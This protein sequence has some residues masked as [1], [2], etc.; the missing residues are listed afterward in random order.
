MTEVLHLNVMTACYT[1]EPEELLDGYRDYSLNPLLSERAV[2]RL[3][4]RDAV[5]K[6]YVITDH[7]GTFKPYFYVPSRSDNKE[8]IEDFFGRYVKRTETKLPRNVPHERENYKFTDESDVLFEW[9][10]LIDKKIKCGFKLHLNPPAPPLL[11]P[12]EPLDIMPRK[13]Y[14]D[15]E[16]AAKGDLDIREPAHPCVLITDYDS[17]THELTAFLHRP[18]M[19]LRSELKQIIARVIKVW[20]VEMN[21]WE[22][23]VLKLPEDQLSTVVIYD[24]PNEF[25]TINMWVKHVSEIDPDH[26]IGHNAD[27]FDFPI[28]YYRCR[29]K[30]WRGLMRRLSPVGTAHMRGEY[31]YIKGREHID[32]CG[33]KEKH[34]GMYTNF[35]VQ[36]TDIDSLTLGNLAEH[37]L[38]YTY[39]FGKLGFLASDLWHS[40]NPDDLFK[41]LWYGLE[42]AW[43]MPRIDVKKGM[44]SRYET[45]RQIYGCSTK[46]AL[47][48]SRFIDIGCLRITDKPLPYVPKQKGKKMKKKQIEGAIVIRPTVGIHGVMKTE[49]TNSN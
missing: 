45:F 20:E 43:V 37:E 35:T 31:P 8:K 47:A 40:E 34:D 6:R 3:Y 48:N 5:G 24:C 17:Y 36:E 12:A 10:F 14:Y 1:E 13:L 38:G 16:W 27:R 15:S 18:K 2:V 7:R 29:E 19:I 44:S 41:L 32:F 46:D 21:R 11:E 42:D 25:Q 39:R 23:T 4:C 9:R 28:L 33:S 49:P 26:M 22:R 30:N